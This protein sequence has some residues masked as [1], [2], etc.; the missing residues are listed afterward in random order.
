MSVVGVVT[1]KADHALFYESSSSRRASFTL[2]VVK[3]CITNDEGCE[4]TLAILLIS[5][6]MFVRYDVDLT[7]NNGVFIH[8]SAGITNMSVINARSPFTL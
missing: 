8:Y 3:H 1:T 4:C 6:S 5:Q 7:I 2:Q